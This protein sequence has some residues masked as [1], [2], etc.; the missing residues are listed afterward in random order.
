M[1]FLV[2]SGYKPR[3]GI[4]GSYG[5][6]IPNFKRNLHIVFHSGSINLHSHPQYKVVPFSPHPLQHM[7]FVHFLVM[8][9]LTNVRGHLTVVLICVSLIMSGVEHLFMCLLSIHMSGEIR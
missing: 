4:A 3:S 6:F 9:I 8:A 2:S 7:L 5:G 1:S